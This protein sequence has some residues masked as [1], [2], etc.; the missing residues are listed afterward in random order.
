MID[1]QFTARRA[2]A[3]N[4]GLPS[5]SGTSVALVLSTFSVFTFLDFA[6]ANSTKGRCTPLS[7]YAS[8]F[9]GLG[10]TSDAGDFGQLVLACSVNKSFQVT[11]LG[12]FCMHSCVEEFRRKKQTLVSLRS[13]F[14][15]VTLR[16]GFS[17]IWC[18]LLEFVRVVR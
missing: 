14:K 1:E 2:I 15:L 3:V 10:C 7:A 13:L 17:T 18:E 5:T 6:S 16:G 12:F 9:G 4:D 8:R 11:W